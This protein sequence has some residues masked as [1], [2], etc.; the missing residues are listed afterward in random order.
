M[1]KLGVTALIVTA[2][3]SVFAP[4]DVLN[5]PVEEEKSLEALPEAVSPVLITG[6]ITVL[7]LTFCVSVVPS[8]VPDGQVF[9]ANESRT[10]LHASTLV[11]ITSARTVLV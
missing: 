9:A 4:V 5:V 10:L 11:P 6:L 2:P 3:P 8:T 1:V 7:L